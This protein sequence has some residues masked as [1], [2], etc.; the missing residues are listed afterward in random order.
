MAFQIVDRAREVL[1]EGFAST[2]TLAEVAREVGVS[3]AYLS[4]AF[5]AATGGT[6]HAFREGLRLQRA[7]DLLPTAC[8]DFTRV[9]LDLGYSSH[10]HFSSRFRRHFG[11]TPRE[12]VEARRRTVADDDRCACT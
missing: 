10:S 1:A 5:R 8:G 2:R 9:A 4:R 12:F 11:M 7:L 6:L 3:P